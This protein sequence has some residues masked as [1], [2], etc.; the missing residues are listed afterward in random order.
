MANLLDTHADSAAGA[1]DWER[2]LRD[3]G[4]AERAT[5]EKAYLKSDLEFAG[6]GVPAIRS[7]VTGWCKARPSLTHDEVTGLVR[8]LWAS[9]L[10]E[11]RQA[12]V[13]LLERT[14]RLLGPADI[15]LI[16]HL[17]MTSHTWAL[18]DGLA[19]NV[20]GDLAER[21]GELGQVLDRWSADGDFWLRRSA[22][23]ALLRPLRVGGG[24]FER[25]AR[26]AVRHDGS[27]GRQATARSC[28]QR[29]DGRIPGQDADPLGAF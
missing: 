18:V 27:R 19:I 25:F 28:A 6:T 10:F 1:A 22:L 21:F 13:V 16:E 17:L 24:D 8:A 23:L 12:A 5:G 14:T 9:P 29:L 15:P 3:D 11:C 26:Y 20:T 4:S 7:M 2:R